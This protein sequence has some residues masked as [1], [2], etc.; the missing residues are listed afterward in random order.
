MHE[1]FLD[2][3]LIEAQSGGLLQSEAFFNLFAEAAVESGDI[4]GVEYCPV[5]SETAFGYRI[6]G[7]NL[8]AELGELILAITDY[9]HET[10]LQSLNAAGCESLF[11]KAWR[12]YQKCQSSKFVNSVEDSSP[13]GQAANLIY[14]NLSAI[15]RVRV[16]VFSNAKLAVRKSLVT[17]Q[18]IDDIRVSFSIIDF[19]R[20]RGIENS[21]N[22]A[23][24]IEIDLNS[25]GLSPLPCLEA[26]SPS[27][28]YS[29]YLAVMPASVLAEI[30]GMYGARLLEANVRTFL[31]AR[32]KV[33]KGI[34]T[35]LRDEPQN[36]LA[37]NNGLTATASDIVV[38]KS[39][40]GAVITSISDLQIVNG[41]QTTASILYARDKE[42][43]N[44]DGVYVQMK[45]SVVDEAAAEEIVPKI[46]KFAN[47]Q[48]KISEADFFA[49]H[50]FHL[51]LERQSRRISAPP[52][53]G[54][55]VSTKWFY[56]RARGQYNDAQ[57][58][59][60]TSQRKRFQ[61][62]HPKSQKVIKT[63]LAKYEMSFEG[64]PH[65]VSKGAQK[66]FL[67]Y[68]SRVE[69]DWDSQA[70]N[71]GDGFFKDAMARALVFR[72][73]D[74]MIGTSNWYQNDRGYK[75]QIVTYSI[76][77]LSYL[78]K[79]ERKS[80]DFRRIWN[81][82]ELPASLQDVLA[83]LAPEVAQIIKT[84]PQTVRNISEFCKTQACWALV[85]REIGGRI[86]FRPPTDCTMDNSEAKER[87]ND[88]RKTR[89]ADSGIE[90]QKL[91]FELGSAHWQT[92]LEFCETNR[93]GSPSEISILRL[94]TRIP[95]T[96]PTEKQCKIAIRTLAAA[97]QEG[98]PT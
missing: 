3:V 60:P 49:S 95:S 58:Y 69:K 21:R 85:K 13:A 6:D 76:A 22:A 30:Y 97:E 84:P 38:S 26:S 31:Q 32:T 56:E 34:Q 16:V 33:N 51:H 27:V 63:D 17:T 11:K 86:T 42:K 1:E 54:E 92:V 20:Y 55:M 78:L 47:S 74:K 53:D 25:P 44:L 90:C 29:S 40:E 82:Q 24:P 80:L 52:R 83:G 39:S 61:T 96:I 67:E 59:M 62:E 10:E 43:T 35:T 2:E 28:E 23:D 98:F 14:A 50:P 15:K 18:T 87:S 46:S 73:T 37:Y 66:C 5:L 72:W 70:L 65:Q 57:A 94:C 68:A 77:A 91:V 45:L 71:F 48:N 19:E 64:E 81:A 8:N 93:I 7:Y 75:A 36:F 41:G 79:R 4:E 89:K 12:F 88:D 9:R